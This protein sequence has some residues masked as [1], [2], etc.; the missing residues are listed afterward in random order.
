M[1][2]SRQPSL[3]ERMAHRPPALEGGVNL[4]LKLEDARHA[5][6]LLEQG[7]HRLSLHAAALSI[8]YPSGLQRLLNAEPEV[9]AIVTERIPPG[10]KAAADER[11]IGYLDRNGRGRLVGPGFVYV[12][13]PLPDFSKIGHQPSSPFAPKASRVVRALLSNP[14]QHWRLSD[15]AVLVNLNPGNVHRALGTLQESGYVERDGDHY[16]LADPG[17]LLEAWADVAPAPKERVSI[18]VE[19]DLREDVAKLVAQLEGNA[20]VSGELAA[21]LLAPHLPARSAIVHCLDLDVW[22]RLS[23]RSE[24]RSLLSLPLLGAPASGHILV[25]LPDEGVV[26]FSTSVG[27]LDLVGPAQL[28][29]DLFRDPARGRQAA[30]EVRRQLLGY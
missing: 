5:Q 1:A 6:L 20:V 19:G 23:Q 28:Y 3:L 17:S 14:S 8:P 18:P 22:D 15:I 11:G 10:L 16:V 13:Q 25:D 7:D 21:E 26:Q 30:E 24:Q 12:A 9:E 27:T 29:V 4:E 2:S